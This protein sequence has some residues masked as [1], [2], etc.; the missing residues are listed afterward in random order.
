MG[1]RVENN[2]GSYKQKRY[3]C[4]KQIEENVWI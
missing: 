2:F 3:Y 4:L 1:V